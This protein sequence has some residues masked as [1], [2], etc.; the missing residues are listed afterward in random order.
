MPLGAAGEAPA[1]APGRRRSRKLGSNRPVAID[2]RVIAATNRDSG[3]DDARRASS[4][5]T[6]TTGCRSSRSACRRCASGATRSSRSSSTSCVEYAERYGR[7]LMRPSP[8]LRDA[9]VS[10]ALAGQRARARERREALRHPAGRRA[11]ARRARARARGLPNRRAAPRCAGGNADAGSHADCRDADGR[12]SGTRS[13]PRR[14][15]RPCRRRIAPPPPIAAAPAPPVAPAPPPYIE[16]GEAKL[17]TLARQAA[18][19]A[20]REAISQALDRFRWN[21]RK[22]AQL[23]G[24]SYKT[25]LNKMKECGI[26]ASS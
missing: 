23:L 7:P 19:V 6:S 17:P 22:A 2:V 13:R 21:R 4:A 8:R 12:G 26:S 24:V 11:R 3:G 9:L 16:L 20:E 25:L 1:R 10:Y 15:R 5:R 18:L 14:S